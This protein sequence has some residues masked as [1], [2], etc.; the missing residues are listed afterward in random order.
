MTESFYKISHRDLQVL[1]REY[2]HLPEEDKR[3]IAYSNLTDRSGRYSRHDLE[4]LRPKQQ[5]AFLD[6]YV[7][8]KKDQN[9]DENRSRIAGIFANG[10]TAF[11]TGCGSGSFPEEPVRRRLHSGSLPTQKISPQPGQ[12]SARTTVPVTLIDSTVCP[13]P[14]VDFPMEG[15]T[16]GKSANQFV[17]GDEDLLRG[18]V[19]ALGD[20]RY[21]LILTNNHSGEGVLRQTSFHLDGSP[22][23]SSGIFW[24]SLRNP[25]RPVVAK[26][27]DKLSRYLKQELLKDPL[28]R[29]DLPV[30]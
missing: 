26:K 27:E 14:P 29:A 7:Q 1:L 9:Y 18:G 24:S 8:W 10:F 3:D 11:L 20:C 21:N 28:F 19:L 17:S 15:E 25:T 16:I 22:L 13:I 5:R 12:A 2:I 6:G 30:E 23:G 4:S